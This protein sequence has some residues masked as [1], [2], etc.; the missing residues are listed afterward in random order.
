[1]YLLMIL[2]YVMWMM[3]IDDVYRWWCRCVCRWWCRWWCIYV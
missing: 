1:M 2:M 3:Y